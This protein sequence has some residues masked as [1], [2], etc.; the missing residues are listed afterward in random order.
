MYEQMEKF[1]AKHYEMAVNAEN[2]TTK[3][4]FFDQAFGGLFFAIHIC[5]DDWDEANRYIELWTEVW[6]PKFT[7]ELYGYDVEVN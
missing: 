6:Y 2:T 3:R 5:G 7:K 1:L 4:T